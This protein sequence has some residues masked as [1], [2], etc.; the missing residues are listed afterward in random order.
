[1]RGARLIQTIIALGCISILHGQT[2]NLFAAASLKESVTEISKAFQRTHRNV[3]FS[4]NFGG[5]QQLVAQIRQGAPVDIL[6]SADTQAL[7]P[8]TYDKPSLRVFATN[9]LA[10]VVPAGSSA[11]RR[12]QDLARNVR[13]I[14]ADAH[15]PVGHYTEAMLAK[16]QVDWGRGWVAKFRQNIVSKEQDVRAVL[17]KVVL[18]EADA[19][20]VYVT[21]AMTAKGKVRLIPIA[22][23]YNVVAQYPVVQ[24]HD[25]SNPEIAKEFVKFLF[26]PEAQKILA[27]HGFGP[28]KPLAQ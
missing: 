18:G 25:A 23:R 9:K 27:K 2:F 16:A 6:L 28:P 17:A 19:G 4:L 12:L 7:R 13:L 20:I 21:D 26:E 8:L 15:V 10:I 5:S 22:D 11:V 3:V 24:F 1:M 14:V